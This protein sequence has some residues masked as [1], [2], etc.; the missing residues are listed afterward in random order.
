MDL[1][2]LLQHVEPSQLMRLSRSLQPR[3]TE[4]D[5]HAAGANL[6]QVLSEGLPFSRVDDDDACIGIDGAF[7]LA[8]D[9]LN[10]MMLMEL[11]CETSWIRREEGGRTIQY[12]VTPEA[13][14]LSL[15]DARELLGMLTVAT[16]SEGELPVPSDLL[17]ARFSAALRIVEM[18]SSAEATS[19]DPFGRPFSKV[20]PQLVDRILSQPRLPLLCATVALFERGCN[21]RAVC[22]TE[23]EVALIERECA[24]S[25][26]A[27]LEDLS[28]S[29]PAQFDLEAKAQFRKRIAST[30]SL[31]GLEDHDAT[32][33][34]AIITEL[35]RLPVFYS[36]D[37][38]PPL[39]AVSSDV[40]HLPPELCDAA[41]E[42][43]FEVFYKTSFESVQSFR[44]ALSELRSGALNAHCLSLLFDPDT[45]CPQRVAEAIGIIARTIGEE[46]TIV[47]CTTDQDAL[48]VGRQM[49]TSR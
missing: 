44:N 21:T 32:A 4:G 1:I 42:L 2:T 7:Y 25:I 37:C 30:L 29:R 5:E 17:G 43:L 49:W 27:L 26:G 13:S 35:E 6:I 18:S 36:D 16:Y 46:L 38:P 48:V 33:L 39:E 28:S 40:Q 45:V 20:P 10:D 22:Y 12:L 34:A 9:W 14:E 3:S 11:L 23:H 31:V 19:R 41:L 8:V 15:K 47:N 24:V